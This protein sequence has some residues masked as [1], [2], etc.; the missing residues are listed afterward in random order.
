[1][2]IQYWFIHRKLISAVSS[3]IIDYLP[4]LQSIFKWTIGNTMPENTSSILNC[5][6]SISKNT[7]RISWNCGWKKNLPLSK[8]RSAARPRKRKRFWMNG[9]R[10]FNSRLPNPAAFSNPNIW[11]WRYISMAFFSS[12]VTVLQTLVIALGAGL[13]IWGVINL[14]EGYG[15]DNPGAN[16]HV[17]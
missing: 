4:V 8:S 7:C 10:N 14:L 16:A 12:A 6:L 11:I 15:N 17:R 1:M 9:Q 2:S 13:G 3:L 5:T